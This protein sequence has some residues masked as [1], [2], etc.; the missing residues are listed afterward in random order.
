MPPRRGEPSQGPRHGVERADAAAGPLRGLL[1]WGAPAAALWGRDRLMSADG[2]AVGRPL[3]RTVCRCCHFSLLARAYL[4]GVFV[5]RIRNSSQGQTTASKQLWRGH[6]RRRRKVVMTSGVDA[7][8][9]SLV[10]FGFCQAG[11]GIGNRGTELLRA[12]KPNNT[13]QHPTSNRP[14]EYRKVLQPQSMPRTGRC[15]GPNTLK[16]GVPTA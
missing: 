4:A 6:A 15:C 8:C 9:R 13:Q 1:S 16:P 12:S 11:T 14:T 3:S 10:R 5:K 7:T 2:R